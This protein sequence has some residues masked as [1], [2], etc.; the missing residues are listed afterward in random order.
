[1]RGRFEFL[2]PRSVEEAQELKA[3][4]EGAKYL[5]GG[6]DLIVRM[7]ERK[8][9]PAALVSLRRI[10]ELSGVRAD[11]FVRV[12]SATPIADCI[13]DPALSSRFPVLVQAMASMGS[14]QIRNVATVGGNLCTASPCADTAPPLL[15]LGA[16]LAVRRP[17]G[18][19]DEIPLEEFFL[20]PR[21][22]RLGPHDLVTGVVLDPPAPNARAI[23]FKKRRVAMDLALA[24]VAVLL[25]LDGATCVKARVAVGSV[26]PTPRRLESVERLLTGQEMKRDLLLA[27]ANLARES[28]APICDLRAGEE[29]RRHITGV[30]VRRA[31][32]TLLGQARP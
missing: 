18:Q 3:R 29:Y 28:V 26:A 12:G 15:V 19:E 6:T 1:M 23:F 7:K 22:T 11:G 32:E 4:T 10:A 13:G 30:F 17:G 20:G 2:R 9:S 8:E 5:A 16:R 24:S 27:A 31:L 21:Q 14:V 25:E